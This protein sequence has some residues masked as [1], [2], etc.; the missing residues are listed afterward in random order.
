MHYSTPVVESD[1]VKSSSSS[2]KYK[3]LVVLVHINTSYEEFFLHLLHYISLYHTLLLFIFEGNVLNALITPGT[4]LH[5][6]QDFKQ[7]TGHR[8][9]TAATFL[10]NLSLRAATND[11]FGNR[12]I[13]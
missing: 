4:V 1:Q 7:T 3:F 11:Y 8:F 9:V 5:S 12:L 6:E 13:G 2:E 10:V